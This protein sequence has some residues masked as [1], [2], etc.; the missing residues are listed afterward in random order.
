MAGEQGKTDAELA[1]SKT[2][3]DDLANA[4]GD[5]G[6][7][8]EKK[9]DE[10]GKQEQPPRETPEQAEKKELGRL[11]KRLEDKFDD[12]DRKSQHLDNLISRLEARTTP[13]DARNN[14][15]PEII[16]TA[17]D[18]EKVLEIRD[19]KL[20]EADQTYQR[21]YVN[22]FSRFKKDDADFDD[23]W[24]EMVTNFNVRRGNEKNPNTWNPSA[25]AE[26]NYLKAKN[27]VLSKKMAGVKGKPNL[28]E[29][30]IETATSIDVTSRDSSSRGKEVS[31]DQQSLDFLKAVGRD[32]KWAA[33]ALKE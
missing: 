16:S 26:I 17:G 12:L 28:K 4:L 10:K 9:G 32:S 5:L 20:V 6:I 27:A 23:V 21:E 24:K 11:R 13:T 31:L 18:V 7:E 3:D 30:K 15:V 19:R 29:E 22:T 2:T 8:A 1:G 25:D 33:E 14:D